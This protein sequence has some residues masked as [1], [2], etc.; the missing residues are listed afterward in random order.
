MDGPLFPSE[1][2][3]PKLITQSTLTWSTRPEDIVFLYLNVWLKLKQTYCCLFCPKFDKFWQSWMKYVKH[4]QDLSHPHISLSF[5]TNLSQF[6]KFH[7]DDAAVLFF[8]SCHKL[9]FFSVCAPEKGKKSNYGCLLDKNQ[10]L[11]IHIAQTG[12]LVLG[13]I[14]T[15]V[16]KCVFPK[17]A[18]FP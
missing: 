2:F 9:H 6:I 13:P 1:L 17:Y 12:F 15:N 11:E 18:S 16:R 5:R 10:N 4:I 8:N 14:E 7:S 3:W